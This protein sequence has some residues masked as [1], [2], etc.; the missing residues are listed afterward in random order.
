MSVQDATEERHTNN[1]KD[2]S[3]LLLGREDDIKQKG[4]YEKESVILRTPSGNRLYLFFLG[5]SKKDISEYS[6]VEILG[7]ACKHVFWV[8]LCSIPVVMLMST[9]AFAYSRISFTNNCKEN[10]T[11]SYYKSAVLL[12]GTN[13]SCALIDSLKATVFASCIVRETVVL[14][15]N[16]LKIM[17]PTF[18]LV[19]LAYILLYNYSISIWYYYIDVGITETL[20][21][22]TFTLSFYRISKYHDMSFLNLIK[23]FIVPM[24]SG[25]LGVGFTEIYLSKKFVESSGYERYAIR[26]VVYPLLVDIILNFQEYGAR[27]LM[28]TEGFTVQ[29]LAHFIYGAQVAFGILGRYMTTTS[30]SLT[31]VAIVSGLIAVKDIIMHRACRFQCWL[32]YYLR[33]L[34]KL[35]DIN[36]DH[37]TFEDWFYNEDYRNFRSCILSNDFVCELVTAFTVPVLV[38]SFRQH[39]TLFNFDYDY[40]ADDAGNINMDFFV[41][42][43]AIQLLFL[44]LSFIAVTY[45]EA[46]F[47]RLDLRILYR[48]HSWLQE[49]SQFVIYIWGVYLCLSSVRLLPNY[50]QCSSND[51]C[52]CN[53]NINR[54]LH[55]CDA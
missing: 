7:V 44:F 24:L 27:Q 18:L 55:G 8:V 1:Y 20:F 9:I 25:V 33:R 51:I 22:T 36:D 38:V 15:S 21:F 14:K 48:N 41:K 34:F 28:K 47:N 32:G 37:G 19:F 42:Q 17:L 52:H 46:R 5:N 3:T 4:R 23:R 10:T 54:K 40:L 53:V 29:G 50:F 31:N 35:K 39:R 30:G 45:I 2:T 6:S 26:L 16:I 12:Y 11:C 49:S 13:V 43:E